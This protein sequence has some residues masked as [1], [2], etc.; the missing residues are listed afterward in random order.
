M[1]ERIKRSDLLRMFFRCFL[2]QGSWNYRSMIGL[3]FS[4]CSLPILKR[5]Y[6]NSKEQEE[7]LRRHL[8]FFNSHP[9]F[10]G[11]CLGAVAKLEEDAKR[12]KWGDDRPIKIFKERLTGP[13]GAIGDGL[14]WNGIKPVS[15]GIGVFL[16]LVLGWIAIPVFLVLYNIPHIYFR[17]TGIFESYKKGFDI[18]SDLTVRRYKKWFTVIPII[19]IIVAGLTITAAA[20]RVLLQGSSALVSFVAAIIIVLIFCYYKKPINSALLFITVISILIGAL[21]I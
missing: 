10:V 21:S 20:N 6:K 9:Y 8:E 12:K 16:S 18:I 1:A 2:I 7:F 5:L 14:F 13:L 19:G 11:W 17:Y 4:Y 15:A 3:G